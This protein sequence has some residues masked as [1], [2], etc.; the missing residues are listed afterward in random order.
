MVRICILTSLSFRQ[1]T[2]SFHIAVS[3]K[4]STTEDAQHITILRPIK[5][6]EPHLYECLASVFNLDYPPESLS[7]YLCVS[8]SSDSA[9]P[10]LKRLLADFPGFDVKIFVEEVDPHSNIN[11]GPNLKIRNMSRPYR[12]AKSDIIW[13]IDSNVWIGKDAARR[14]ASTLCGYGEHG[15]KTKPCK[16]VHQLPLVIDCAR[17]ENPGIGNETSIYENET[18][19]S[20]GLRVGGG[21]LEE[22]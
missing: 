9:L 12:E 11:L 16:L 2:P 15:M 6:I 20:K 19:F 14:M 21:W 18:K 3:N 17:N 7:I 13:I 1:R 22:M 4:S 10:L 8:S 5:G